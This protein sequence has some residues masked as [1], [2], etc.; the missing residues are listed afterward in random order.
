M[1]KVMIKLALILFLFAFLLPG[2]FAAAPAPGNCAISQRAECLASEG[3]HILMGL[4]SA[5]NA[6]GEFPDQLINYDYVLCCGFGDGVNETECQPADDPDN[7]IVKLSSFTNAHA[8][9]PTGSAY[10]L[11]RVC[12]EDLRCKNFL[13]NCGTGTALNYPLGILSLSA[14]TN[15]HIGAIGDYPTKIC[16]G[17]GLFAG[18]A[19]KNA[20]WSPQEA[21]EGQIIHLNVEGS[22]ECASRT[23]AFKVD[24]GNSPVATQPVSVSFTGAQGVGVWE[25][26]HQSG[27]FLGLGDADYYFDASLLK[28]P[29]VVRESNP[30]E[31]LVLERAED[32][33]AGIT[34]CTDYS[35]QVDCESDS[36][37][38]NVGNQES[39]PGIDCNSDSFVCGCTWN[40]E[41]TS[42]GFGYT[43]LT[44][45]TCGTPV[46]GQGCNYGCTLCH[47][48]GGGNSTSGDYCNLGSSCPTG[49]NPTTNNDGI[50]DAG[51]GCVSADCGSGEQDSCASG[52]YC[53][54]G[55]CSSVLPPIITSG[56]CEIKQSVTKNCNDEP[57]GY[58]IAKLTTTWAGPE[59]PGKAAC[60]AKN[61]QEVRIS[62]PAQV[63]LP[64]FDYIGIITTVLAI[65]GIYVSIIL[66]KRFKKA[67][68]K[69]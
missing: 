5:T 36:S 24:G 35:N 17:S 22:P 10:N 45:E 15:A 51:E 19:I 55:K 66:R 46:A 27:G 50:C 67:K 48:A 21:V 30:P 13:D 60:D 49:E 52:F 9:S 32:Y 34:S 44:E 40:N 62:C 6:H 39:I 4:S 20:E 42:C 63:A 18:C 53:M 38:C 29:L 11:V 7:A 23:I 28:N 56:H 43:E 59:S 54:S 16:C 58:K 12:Y 2:I 8:E 14:T 69:K 57:A 41:T 31:L 64:F 33:C 1:K 68:E 47:K 26:E 65:A 61:G 3:N 37:V 25:A